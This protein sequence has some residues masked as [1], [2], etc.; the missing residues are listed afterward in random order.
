MVCNELCDAL[1]NPART[2]Y[3][4]PRPNPNVMKELVQLFTQIALS[5]KGPQDLP[6]S[7]VLLAGTV[8][9]YLL[10]NYIVSL[11]LPPIT[12]WRLHLFADIA[13]TV[14]WYAAL[15]RAFGKPERF[16]QTT[17]AMFGYQLVLAPLWIVAIYLSR[18]YTA[19]TL[20]Q[21][22]AAVIGLAIAIWIIRA[23]GHVLKAALELPMAACV[24][25][26]ILQI[27]AGQL[28]LIALTP[29]DPLATTTAPAAAPAPVGAPAEVP[30]PSTPAN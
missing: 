26:I 8:V 28:V 12:P 22:P 15:L 16:M 20:L 7:S 21:F 17:T 27:L 14:L 24:V 19:D 11:V 2:F 3:A 10:V 9:A 25:L 5:R 29:D 1:Y 23:G 6:A 18:Q 30:P 4:R 13:F